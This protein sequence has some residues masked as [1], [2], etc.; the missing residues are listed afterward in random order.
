MFKA[1]AKWVVVL[2]VAVPLFVTAETYVAGEHYEVLP[3]AVD[4]GVEDGVEVVEIF[5]YA[6]IHC[7]NFD[8]MLEGWRAGIDDDVTFRRI[9]AI[10]NSVWQILAQA[11]Y[12]AEVLDVSDAMHMPLFEAIHKKGVDIRDPVLLAG[13]FETYARVGREDFDQVFNSFS[14]RSRVQQADARGRAYR[15]TGVPTLIVNGKYRV[16][17]RM[18]GGNQAML[19]VVDHLVALEQ[20]AAAA[21]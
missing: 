18:A 14:V 5:S 8:P 1:L 3:L 4:T 13:L 7:F 6:C 9:P 16:D 10:F 15:V 19:D 12:T 21:E 2:S 17:G 20:G 11:Y